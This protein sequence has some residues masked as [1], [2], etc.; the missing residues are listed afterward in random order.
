MVKEQREY[1]SF[2]GLGSAEI[3]VRA[4]WGRGTPDYNDDGRVDCVRV[5]RRMQ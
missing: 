4:R 1:R 2:F 3:S 5:V